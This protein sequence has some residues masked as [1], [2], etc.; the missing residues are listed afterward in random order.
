MSLNTSNVGDALA[1][2]GL[3]FGEVTQQGQ[4]IDTPP[5]LNRFGA[6]ESF[7]DA[8]ARLV[9]ASI[10]STFPR[11]ARHG[12]SQAPA[13]EAGSLMEQGV[14]AMSPE[15]LHNRTPETP[16]LEAAVDQVLDLKAGGEGVEISARSQ[17][18]QSISTRRKF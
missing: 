6:G 11:I 17:S 1:P 16:A 14:W 15:T 12:D 13:F 5:R 18:S 7:G 2:S 10:P 9:S 4:T 8:A 3:R